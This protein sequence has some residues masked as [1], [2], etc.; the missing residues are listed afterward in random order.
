MIL[1]ATLVG[2][3]AIV[4]VAERLVAVVL[5]AT[6]F[7]VGGLAGV[8]DVIAVVVVAVVATEDV[9]SLALVFVAWTPVTSK[10]IAL[11]FSFAIV[12]STY[13]K[14]YP[15]IACT[16]PT[17]KL[18][19][20]AAKLKVTGKPPV[21]TTTT[22]T[23]TTVTA[24]SSKTP[25]SS[26]KKPVVS[27]T[28]SSTKTTKRPADLTTATAEASPS[29]KKR[30]FISL[31]LKQQFVDDVRS[32]RELDPKIPLA[33]IARREKYDF[34]RM[35]ASRIFR[36]ADDIAAKVKEIWPR[37]QLTSLTVGFWTSRK[38]TIFACIGDMVKQH[39]PLSAIVMQEQ[40]R[41]VIGDVDKDH[42]MDQLKEELM[43][44]YPGRAQAIRR[45]MDFGVLAY[46]KCCEGKGPNQQLVDAIKIVA[47]SEKFKRFFLPPG[48]V[49]MVDEDQEDDEALSDTGYFPPNGGEGPSKVRMQTRRLMDVDLAHTR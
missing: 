27:K 19:P 43:V 29:I 2:D 37:E 48:S 41:V 6:R 10:A 25:S 21:V 36:Q 16:M 22:T 39:R 38:T 33:S 32:A 42:E 15:T 30:R 31:A 1:H 45:Q 7:F 20:K 40:L 23:I 17:T 12:D 5:V 49:I 34:D 18:T 4:P 13:T 26:K 8:A 9:F 14:F 35:E 47:N 11:A 24:V 28:K 46:L 44:L 3:E